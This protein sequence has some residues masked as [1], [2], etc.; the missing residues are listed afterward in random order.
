[1]PALNF[2]PLGEITVKQFGFDEA[3]VSVVVGSEPGAGAAG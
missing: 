1:M 2:V 3:H